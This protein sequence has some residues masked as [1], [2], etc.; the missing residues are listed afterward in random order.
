MRLGDP[1]T[2]TVWKTAFL[3]LSVGSRRRI[4]INLAMMELVKVT[5]AFFLR[6]K[7]ASVDPSV[8][9]EDMDMF[10]CFRASPRGAK[11]MLTM[12]E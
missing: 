8:T 4:G 6:F 7:D 2:M 10:D 9:A 5:A 12:L 1:R 11:L 3:P